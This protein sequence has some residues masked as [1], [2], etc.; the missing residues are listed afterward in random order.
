MHEDRQKSRNYTAIDRLPGPDGT[1]VQPNG[2]TPAAAGERG[3]TANGAIIGKEALGRLV[4]SEAG[5]DKGTYLVIVGVADEAHVLLADGKLRTLEKPKLKKL[6]HLTVTRHC[7]AGIAERLISGC[8]I[9]NAELRKYIA[10]CLKDESP[11]DCGEITQ[12]K[13]E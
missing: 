3:K 10:S 6:R 4:R 13:E 7:S 1:T 11:E 5:H 2:T 8:P 12:V 9:R